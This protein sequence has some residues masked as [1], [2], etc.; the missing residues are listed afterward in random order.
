MISV[1]ASFCPSQRHTKSLVHSSWPHFGASTADQPLHGPLA[2]VNFHPPPDL[3][4]LDSAFSISPCR[5]ISA[6]FR[7]SIYDGIEDQ[8]MSIPAKD[9]LSLAAFGTSRAFVRF[10]NRINL[11]EVA[12]PD[13]P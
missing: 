4:D 3:A 8:P 5:S 13:I 10:V 12:V 6:F 2:L 11:D 1:K 7:R 9:K